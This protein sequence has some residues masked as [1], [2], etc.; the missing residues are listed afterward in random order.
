LF[1]NHII[2]LLP[3]SLSL[4]RALSLDGRKRFAV[5]EF[6]CSPRFA[7]ARASSPIRYNLIRQ[8]NK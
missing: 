8:N 4:S 6:A 3:C 5:I 7:F 2:H 1:F